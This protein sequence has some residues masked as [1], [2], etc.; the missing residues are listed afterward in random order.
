MAAPAERFSFRTAL[1]FLAIFTNVC[2][3][4]S[5]K[6]KRKI[7]FRDFSVTASLV[8]EVGLRRLYHSGEFYSESD[9]LA[10]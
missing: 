4:E 9:H 10:N 3:P 8:T 7:Q 1:I 5:E 6:G 2:N